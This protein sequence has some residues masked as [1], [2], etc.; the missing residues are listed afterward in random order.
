[1]SRR[2]V[3]AVLMALLTLVQGQLWLGRGS[4]G[5]VSQLEQKLQLQQQQNALLQRANERLAAEVN[6]LKVGQEMVEEK[7]RM[8]LGMLRPGEIFVQYQR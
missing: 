4:L 8:E 1:M 5:T 3:T 6:D 7:A 2:A